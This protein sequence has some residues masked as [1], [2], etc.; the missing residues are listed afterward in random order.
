MLFVR[1]ITDPFDLAT[2]EQ[3]ELDG[4]LLV[5]LREKFETW[6]ATARLYRGTIAVENDVTPVSEEDIAALENA[7]GVY[8]VVV[9]PGDP[10]TAIIAVIAVLA[11]VVAM[12]VFLQPRF[13]G[14]GNLG[15]ANNGLGA[16]TNRARPRERIPDIFGSVISVPDLLGEPYRAF[17]SNLEYEIWYGCVG[18]GS[19]TIS[20]IKDGTTPLT[21]IAGAGAAFY[22]PGTSPNFGSPQLQIGT[23]IDEPVLSVARV[24][25]VNGQVLRPPNANHYNASGNVRFVA[26]DTIQASGGVDFTT[27]FDTDD[28][29]TVGNANFGGVISWQSLLEDARCY[30]DKTIV[31]ATFDPSSV[32]EVGQAV[33]IT[34]AVY[35]GVTGG[36]APIT[37]D[38]SGT[39]TVDAVNSTTLTLA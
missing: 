7:D 10:V 34:N 1:L 17:T 35:T 29:L 13:P 19:Y 33:T 20:D 8:Y 38:L 32:F 37:V 31:F 16:R 3:H 14:A 18:R 28:E 4:D 12:L 6:P 22:A 39:Y 2:Y 21:D 30:P 25:A 23:V 24:E 36:G 27:F 9:F 26:P 5:F 15:S 11:L